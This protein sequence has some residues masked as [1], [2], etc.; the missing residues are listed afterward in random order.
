MRTAGSPA[1]VMAAMRDEAAAEVDRVEQEAAARVGA[2]ERALAELTV[3]APDRDRRL[4]RAR[5]AAG[6]RMAREDDLDARADLDV[7]ERWMAAVAARGRQLL[8]SRDAAARR[9]VLTRL[10]VEA[11]AR[12]PGSTAVLELAACDLAAVD[13]AWREAVTRESG[14]Q[15]VELVAGKIGGGCVART[16]D[17]RAAYDNSIEARIDRF[18]PE[19]RAALG[20][21][22]EA[23]RR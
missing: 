10:A 19:C 20:A 7:R 15:G 5:A 12:V 22:F 9:R 17:G 18:L 1:A 16:P 2:L 6:E 8:E 13:L 3:E 21:V 14:K 23:V 11:L 4:A